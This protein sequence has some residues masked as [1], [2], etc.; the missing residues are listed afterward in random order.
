MSFWRKKVVKKPVEVTPAQAKPVIAIEYAG[1]LY[2]TF[3]KAEA[4]RAKSDLMP[5][6]CP[7]RELGSYDIYESS[8]R[9]GKMEALDSVL[10]NAERIHGILSR[11]L[12]AAK[13]DTP[14]I[15]P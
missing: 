3:Q 2:P 9:V 4:A 12:D 5:L 1:S 7:A 11:Y 10:E 6:L 14:K 8:R 15:A 13:I